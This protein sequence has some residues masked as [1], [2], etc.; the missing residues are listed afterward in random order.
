M[1]ECK[2]PTHAKQ[3]KIKWAGFSSE[4]DSWV[5]RSNLHPDAI[6]DFELLNGK[7]DFLWPHRC[8]VCDLPCR[9]KAGIKIDKTKKH[10]AEKRQEF[11][12]S[13]GT[14]IRE[15]TKAKADGALRR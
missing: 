6:K 4:H 5:S 12:G 1:I 2:G 8:D 9:S 11:K 3:S 7:Y 13:Q 10:A 14:K 15:T